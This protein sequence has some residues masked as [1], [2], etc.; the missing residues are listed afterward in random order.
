MNN[1]YR[2]DGSAIVTPVGTDYSQ[3][4]QTWF[5]WGQFTPITITY[6]MT[7]E[8][9]SKAVNSGGIW[10]F[11]ADDYAFKIEEVA[12]LTVTGVTDPTTVHDLTVNPTS[13]SLSTSDT[14]G[15]TITATCTTISALSAIT[16]VSSDETVV[17]INVNGDG[18]ATVTPVAEGTAT[19]TVTA[20]AEGDY[21]KRTRTV[22][23]TVGAGGG[24]SGDE[25]SL[26]IEP[27]DDLWT[28][29]Q[30]KIIG[31]SDL[32][33]VDA[34][35]KFEG[36]NLNNVDFYAGINGATEIRKSFKEYTL[37]TDIISK[38]PV[39]D[40]GTFTFYAV[41]WYSGATITSATITPKE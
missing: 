19:I 20:P 23:V 32:L 7:A 15:Q 30:Y 27:V 11:C 35:L 37:T 3:F 2:S 5:P 4:N 22:K 16:F 1:L 26:T 8:E 24:G 40:E 18:T 13:L 14:E 10:I 21:G 25:G 6:P 29:H 36:E 12:L 39:S 38:I 17:T 9:T 34:T 41:A 33:V 31:N 28:A